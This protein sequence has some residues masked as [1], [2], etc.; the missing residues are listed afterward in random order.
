MA[1]TNYS[2][3]CTSCGGNKW[4]YIKDLKLWR[5]QYCDAQVERQE[6]Y[7]GLYSI[8]NVVRQVILD[9]AY[10]RLEQADRNLSE[11][12]KIN[13]Q[14]VGTLI[15]GIC[16]RLIAAVSGTYPAQDPRAMLGQLRRDYQVLTEESRDMSDDETALYEFLDSSDAWAALATVFDTLGDEV[17]REYLLTLTDA[18]QVFSKETNKSLLRFAV[19]NNRTELIEKILNNEDNLDIQ[20]AFHIIL[21]QCPD[22][23]QK[24]RLG[25]GLL[26]AG[27]LK[28]GEE[29]VLENYLSGDDSVQTKAALTEAACKAGL[30]LHM[31]IVIREVL[32]SAEDE[33]LSRIL[34]TFFDRRLYDGEIELLMSFAAAQRSVT[35]CLAVLDAMVASGQFVSLS[36]RQAQEFMDNSALP[37]QSRLEILS[38]LKQFTGADRLWET[39][40]GNYLCQGRDEARER[41]E[42]IKGLCKDLKSLPAREFEKY[43]LQCTLDDQQKPELVGEILALP[44]MNP[45]FFRDLAGKYLHNGKD[46]PEVKSAVLHQLLENGLSID[47]GMLVD[48]VCSAGDSPDEKVE[49]VQ[50]AVRNGTSIRAD[51]LSIYLERCSGS[52]SPKLFALLYQNGSTVTAKAME[53]YILRCPDDPAVKAKNG[54]VLASRTGM[55]LGSGNCTVNHLGNRVTCSLAQ[56]YLLTTT[57]DYGSASRM[58]QAMTGS[59]TRLNTEIQVGGKGKRFSKYLSENRGSLSQVTEQISQ[60]NRLFSWLF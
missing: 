38:R 12:Q 5:C 42:M 43:V 34:D 26:S 17:R 3:K 22:G 48:Y 1:V 32:G 9:A 18:S 19:K 21:D 50:L 20:D 56:A 7:D 24:A 36:V 37:A 30:V 41:S 52:F 33:V 53:N 15:A 55:S 23:E 11:C 57:D 8:K 47:G 10:R 44:D 27:A 49:L 40:T 28:P 59:G 31:E 51:A 13:A 45:G 35:R 29:E 14:Y 4:E 58:I 16:F 46:Q 2:K 60:D 39:V 25:A 6:Q 54:A